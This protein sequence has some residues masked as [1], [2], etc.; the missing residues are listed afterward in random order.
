VKV[1]IASAL[2]YWGKEDFA[3]Q[4]ADLIPQ[5]ATELPLDD[6]AT[7]GGS[8]EYFDISVDDLKHGE[9]KKDWIYGRF[10]IAFSESYQSGCR[11]ISWDNNYEGTMHFKFN[12]KT[13]EFSAWCGND[14]VQVC[15]EEAT[16]DENA[17][18]ETEP[19]QNKPETPT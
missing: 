4:L 3:A 11:D 15:D 13:G 2:E 14:I 6:Y 17:P 12:I 19:P 18:D 7:S 5:C 16:D 9:P 10:W 1:S 8:I